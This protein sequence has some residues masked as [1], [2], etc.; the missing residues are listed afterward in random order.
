MNENQKQYQQIIKKLQ[1]KDY[2]LTDIRK[3]VI[4]ILVVKKHISINDI[5][6][7]LKKTHNIVNIMS[8]YN[9]I[10]LLMDEHII[11]ANVFDNKQIF[12]E[13]SDNIIHVVC[14]ICHKIIHVDNKVIIDANF[15]VEDKLSSFL[16]RDKN[17]LFSHYKLEVH[18]ICSDC[19]K[20]T[21]KTR[22]K[23]EKEEQ[24]KNLK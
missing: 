15:L 18:G 2:R 5:I 13:L 12:Y 4:E 8:I 24:W 21:Q 20:N 7:E 23:A 6:I 17:F 14:N 10:D 9:T 1:E 22:Q 16:L 19:R 11:H 3:A